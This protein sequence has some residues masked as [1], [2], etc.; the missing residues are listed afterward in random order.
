MGTLNQGRNDRRSRQN[1]KAAAL[2]WLLGA[3]AVCLIIWALVLKA[4]I[5]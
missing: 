3:G 5:G 2:A 1:A 4:I